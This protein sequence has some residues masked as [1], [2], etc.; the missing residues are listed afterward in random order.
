MPCH[1]LICTHRPLNIEPEW[2]IDQVRLTS[3][4]VVWGCLMHSRVSPDKDGYLRQ[5]SKNSLS[6]LKM[7]AS[8]MKLLD[9]RKRVEWSRKL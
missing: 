5:K 6:A 1:I 9:A 4:F 2:V 8:E 3:L 7:F